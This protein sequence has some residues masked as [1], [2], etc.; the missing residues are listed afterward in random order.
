MLTLH[1]LEIESPLEAQAIRAAAEAWGYRVSVTW[2]G[3]SGQIVDVLAHR[4]LHDVLVISGH[5]DERG[6]LLPTLAK[7]VRQ[8]YPYDEVIRPEDFAQ[9]LSLGNNGVIV[10]SCCAGQAALA[11][12]FLAHGARWYIGAEGYPEGRVALMFALA[13]LYHLGAGMSA[14]EAHVRVSQS[15]EVW[16]QFHFYVGQP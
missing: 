1:I 6:L 7:S 8:H 15:D 12:V 5:G 14:A 9:F 16:R 10:T 13:F 3:N 4:P 2:V 11:D